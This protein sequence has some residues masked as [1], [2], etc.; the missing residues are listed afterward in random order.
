MDI[1]IFAKSSSQPELPYCV[2]FT[3]DEGK[4]RVNCSCHAGTYGQLCKHKTSLVQGDESMLHDISQKELL[5][6]IISTI[7][8]SP[9][10]EEYLKLYD[11][12]IEI[13]EKQKELKKE[14]KNIKLGLALKLNNGFKLKTS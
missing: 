14:L 11:K 10:F 12:K 7:K 8:D 5:V 2:N 1:T 13:E 4:L 6:E 9:V 3:I